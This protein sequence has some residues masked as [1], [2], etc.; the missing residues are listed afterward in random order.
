[1]ADSATWSTSPTSTDWSVDV[2]WMPATVPD[3]PSAVATF[4]ASALPQVELFGTSQNSVLDESVAGIV[5]PAGASAYTITA[6]TFGSVTFYGPGVVNHSGIRQNFVTDTVGTGV[7][8]GQFAFLNSSSAGSNLN[9]FTNGGA[10]ANDTDGGTCLFTDDASA[11]SAIF[12]NQGG[13]L[14]KAS[15]GIIFIVDRATA[16]HATITNNGATAAGLEG[17]LVEFEQFGTAAQSTIVNNGADHRGGRGGMV[18]FAGGLGGT[19][20]MTNNGGMA[21]GAGGGTISFPDSGNAGALTIIN[22]GSGIAGAGAG[23]V[24]FDGVSD[25]GAATITNNGG[26]VTG[27]TGSYLSFKGTS[28]ANRAVIVANGGTNGGGGAQVVFSGR[29]TAESARFKIYGNASL[30]TGGVNFGG[31][32]IGSL[33][34]DGLVF[35][36]GQTLGVGTANLSTTFSGTIMDGGIHT[37]AGGYL[38]KYGRGTLVLSGAN[39][40]TGGTTI[41]AGGVRVS[42]SS[43]SGTGTGPV[44]VDGGVLAGSGVIAGAVAVGTSSGA[45]STIA[46]SNGTGKSAALAIQNALSF[47]A[48]GTYKWTVKKNK[49]TA[50][51]L[52]ANGVTIT[53]G[54][55]FTVEVTGSGPITAQTVFTAIN[56]TSANPIGGQFANLADGALITVNGV[57]LKANYEGGDGNDLTLTVQ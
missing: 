38:I 48:A 19:G 30:D 49:A 11:G 50:D 37:D 7:G 22:N 45:A 9:T 28:T 20:T 54:A 32:E 1:L 27:A 56:N 4:A 3:D 23:A 2:N 17:G 6:H 47:D 10:K 36:G 24:S 44:T 33:E 52:I 53:G 18:L 35:L 21:A 29:S 26:T 55:L 42:N 43:G 5:F 41:T 12:V 40:Y 14:T 39:T 25:A 8:I 15:G 46:P 34:G 31:L 13:S 16:S 57:T 51:E